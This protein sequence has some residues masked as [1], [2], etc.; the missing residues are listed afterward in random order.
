MHHIKGTE[1]DFL[2]DYIQNFRQFY[3][4]VFPILIKVLMR[5]KMNMVKGRV[6]SFGVCYIEY[7][8]CLR[9]LFGRAHDK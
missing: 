4:V 9:D 6:H 7:V 3:C 8:P 5:V 1:H 2:K